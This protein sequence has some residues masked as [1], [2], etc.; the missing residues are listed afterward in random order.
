MF[1]AIAAEKSVGNAEENPVEIQPSWAK[2]EGENVQY[3]FDG[4]DWDT[5]DGWKVPGEYAEWQ[6]DVLK[7]GRYEVTIAY[8]CS[9]VKMGGVMKLT[10]GD[11]SI[12]FKVSRAALS[13]VA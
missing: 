13:L 8:G 2:W 3:T 7:A 11:S 1:L 10:A 12:D 4:Y 9:P 6:L 5:I